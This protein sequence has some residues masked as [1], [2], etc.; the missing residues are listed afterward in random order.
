[1][2]EEWEEGWRRREGGGRGREGGGE[3]ECTQNFPVTQNIFKI[4]NTV[5][6]GMHYETHK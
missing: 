1:M 5:L 6:G 3:E 2:E 4:K